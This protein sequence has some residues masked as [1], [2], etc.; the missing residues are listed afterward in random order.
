MAEAIFNNIAENSSYE[1]SSVSRGTNVFFPQKINCKAKQ[2]I[3]ALGIKKCKEFS[4]QLTDSDVKN[5][6]LVLTM[7]SAHKMMLKNAFPDQKAKIFT[8]KEKAYGKDSDVDDPFG[9]SQEIYDKCSLE[10]KDAIEKLLC[11]I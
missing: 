1:H 9:Q 4:E 5:S 3:E 11:I 7:T 6:D 2:S 10:L 8:L